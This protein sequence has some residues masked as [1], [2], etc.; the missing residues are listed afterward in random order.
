MHMFICVAALVILVVTCT[1]PVAST[2]DIGY[3]VRASLV[4]Q[5]YLYRTGHGVTYM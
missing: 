1:S 3:I 2:A 5:C 4:C